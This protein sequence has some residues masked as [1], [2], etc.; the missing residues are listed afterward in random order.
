MQND[1]V[2]SNYMY[3]YHN[4]IYAHAKYGK[5]FIFLTDCSVY[6]MCLV[7]FSV[8]TVNYCTFEYTHKVAKNLACML[9]V[10]F[11]VDS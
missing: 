4:P 1:L 8:Q 2:C 9:F 7:P 5:L 11:K 10:L 6:V 3:I